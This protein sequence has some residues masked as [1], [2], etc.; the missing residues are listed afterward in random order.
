[1]VDWQGTDRRKGRKTQQLM[2]A[3]T[4]MLATH[5]D[6]RVLCALCGEPLEGGEVEAMARE[7][8]QPRL[9]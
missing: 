6:L 4:G 2:P 8:L 3:G 9:T 5:A 7:T 1:M